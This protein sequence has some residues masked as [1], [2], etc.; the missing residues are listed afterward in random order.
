P[1]RTVNSPLSIAGGGGIGA[2]GQAAAARKYRVRD[3][4]I[5]G[6][7]QIESCYDVKVESCRIIC[8]FSGYSTPPVTILA[9]ADDVWITDNE[10]YGRTHNSDNSSLSL[11][12]IE[13]Y[14]DGSIVY[15]TSGIHVRG[16]RDQPRKRN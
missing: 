11:V 10:I 3:C 9:L 14:R 15:Q 4:T 6:S 5:Y 7:V 13:D 8:D 12:T 1:P 16:N 2:W